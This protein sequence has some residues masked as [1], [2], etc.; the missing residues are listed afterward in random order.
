MPEKRNGRPGEG[1]PLIADAGSRCTGN[2]EVIPRPYSSPPARQFQT[3]PKF[4]V[5]AQNRRRRAELAM[6]RGLYGLDP[7]TH[8]E[9]A[10]RTPLAPRPVIVVEMIGSGFLQAQ[11]ELMT[12]ER[13]P[14][15]A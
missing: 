4:P 9:C 10:A 8:G 14:A 3:S 7:K 15:W 13:C 11:T 12:E 2:P 6:L 1:Q 5:S